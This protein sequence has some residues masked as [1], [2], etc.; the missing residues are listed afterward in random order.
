MPEPTLPLTPAPAS[1]KFRA[2][3]RSKTSQSSSGRIIS[4]SYGGQ[5]FEMTL[6]YPTMTAEQFAPINAF[7]AAQK[8]RNEIFYVRVPANMSGSTGTKVGNFAIFDNDWKL[9]MITDTDPVA[10]VPPARQP[11]GSLITSGLY[12]RCSMTSDVHEIDINQ[13]GLFRYELDLVERL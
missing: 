11:G 13:R 2:R 6:V 4:R 5:F 10:V 8:G 12:M 1:V 9:H 7:L 3:H